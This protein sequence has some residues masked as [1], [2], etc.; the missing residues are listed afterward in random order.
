MAYKA[1]IMPEAR[2]AQLAERFLGEFGV[3]TRYF[4]NGA[5]HLPPVQR[6]DWVVESASW[7]AVTDAT[8]DMGVL[9]VGRQRSGARGSKTRTEGRTDAGPGACS[10]KARCP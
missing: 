8:F 10:A 9:A 3:G 2:A 1:E 7:D 6:S 4:S 5:W